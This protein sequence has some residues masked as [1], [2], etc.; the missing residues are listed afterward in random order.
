MAC[1]Q[2][3]GL[4]AN[5]QWQPQAMWLMHRISYSGTTI[6]CTVRSTADGI[7]AAYRIVTCRVVL[8]STAVQG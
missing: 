3:K 7:D 2:L 6:P 5:G 1:A 4:E 8:C